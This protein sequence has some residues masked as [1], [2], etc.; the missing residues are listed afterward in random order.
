MMKQEYAKYAAEDH[1]VWQILY[2][3]QMK[4]L[5]GLACREF[6]QYCQTIGFEHDRIPKVEK[7]NEILGGITGWSIYVVPGL[8]DNKRFFEHLRD[9]EFPATTWLR[10]MEEIDY[11]EEPD[12]FHDIYGHVPLLANA[13]FTGFLEE[14]ARIALKNI[15]DEWCVEMVARLYWYTV[16]FGLIQD[17]EQGLRIYG[18]GILSSSGESVYSIESD[19]PARVPYDVREIVLTPY[20]KDKFQEKYFVIESFEQLYE[21]VGEIE[22]VIEEELAKAKEGATA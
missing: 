4:L 14:L 20:I 19:V 1:E 18:A 22:R 12:M 11:L 10:K 17:K 7:M 15:D 3:R 5:P 9:K 21:S 16:E 2:E 6:M 8:I 13:N